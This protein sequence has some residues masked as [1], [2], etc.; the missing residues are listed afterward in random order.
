MNNKICKKCGEPINLIVFGVTDDICYG[1]LTSKD[2][3]DVINENINILYE[4]T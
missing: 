1:C 3:K 4:K 2:K